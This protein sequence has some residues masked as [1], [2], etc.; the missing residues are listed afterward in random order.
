MSGI[1]PGVL[2]DDR[3]VRFEYRGVV[4]IARDRRRVVEIVETQMQ[5]P[6]CG[7]GEAIRADGIA[8]SE[9]NCDR[10]MCVTIAC[11]V[12]CETSARCENELSEGIYP[13]AMARSRPCPR[14][15]IFSIEVGNADGP[16]F[17][18][19]GGNFS[20]VSCLSVVGG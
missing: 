3:H 5:R 2:Q 11:A 18:A 17:V 10:H 1:E 16:N 6:A 12:S 19:R 7:N 13:S 4:G 14:S 15:V 8:I 9:K 20:W